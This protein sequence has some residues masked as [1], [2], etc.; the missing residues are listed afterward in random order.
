MMTDVWVVIVVAFG[1][2]LAV[3]GL[4]CALLAAL[5]GGRNSAKLH[6]AESRWRALIEH[7]SNMIAILDERGVITYF[8]PSAT[9]ILGYELDTVLGVNWQTFVHPEDAARVTALVDSLFGVAA[10]ANKR[11]VG[12]EVRIRHKDG[13][14]RSIEATLT[15]LLL[16][17]TVRGVV[18]N[19]SDVTDQRKMKQALQ[20]SNERLR[21]LQELADRTRAEANLQR[22]N[23]ELEQRIE[24]GTAQLQQ[25]E[26]ELRAVFD[27]MGESLISLDNTE[28][29]YT[30]RALSELTG[31]SAPELIGQSITLLEPRAIRESARWREVAQTV[32]TGAIWRGE[33]TWYRKDGS[34][35]EVEISIRRVDFGLSNDVG[36]VLVARDIT[37][38]KELGAQKN[39]FIA[40]ASHELRTPLTNF[41]TRLYLIRRQPE[42][43]DEHLAVLER[44]TERMTHLVEDLLDLSRFDRGVIQLHPQRLALQSIVNEVIQ[45]QRPEADR[46]QIK[47]ISSVPAAAVMGT[48]DPDRLTQ[49]LVNLV[50]NAI[51]YTSEGGQVTVQLSSQQDSALIEVRDTGIGIKPEHIGRLF[52]PFFR[53]NELV[54]RG[55][56]LGLSIAHEIVLLHGG[57][58][59]V[60]S[61]PGQGSVFSVLLPLEQPLAIES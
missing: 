10:T 38:E 33:S 25:R 13:G 9:R 2:G 14:W 20:S 56:G 53:A 5:I 15:N 1:A 46:K 16:E 22:L 8:S 29:R 24:S 4:A 34:A 43:F 6:T 42:R 37:V 59:T 17:P 51:N 54:G 32:Q 30:N 61:S 35:F 52:E 58:L 19:A 3:G 40:N 28:I 27:A 57:T 12:I 41:K 39:R 44:V 47:L 48:V 36:T 21:I 49:V 26:S 7:D 55:A 45:T 31:Y 18:M 23:A 60:E 50:I 11:V